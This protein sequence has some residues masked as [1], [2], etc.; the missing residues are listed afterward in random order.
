MKLGISVLCKKLRSKRE[1]CGSRY[2]DRP[3]LAKGVNETLSVS[4]AFLSDLDKMLH[5]ESASNIVEQ[6]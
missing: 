1:F 2:N 6:L 5:K 4:S 3:T